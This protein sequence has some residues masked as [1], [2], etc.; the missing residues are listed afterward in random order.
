MI[1]YAEEKQGSFYNINLYC[2]YS[3]LIYVC[4]SVHNP[5]CYD[6]KL[7]QVTTTSGLC[8]TTTPTEAV[9]NNT[10]LTCHPVGP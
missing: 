5:E 6:S 2:K 8:A 3:V 7:L 9:C 4:R 10:A 1:S